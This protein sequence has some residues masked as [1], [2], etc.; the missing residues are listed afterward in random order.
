[1]SQW[2]PRLRR[3]SL[4][5]LGMVM[6]QHGYAAG[7]PVF[8][9]LAYLESLKQTIEQI[10]QSKTQLDQYQSMLK[11]S[12][13]LDHYT[14][15]QASLTMDN[16]LNAINTL[17][18][19]KQQSGGIDPYLA[20]YQTV[21]HYTTSSCLNGSGCSSAQ[22]QALNQ[23]QANASTAQKRAN[24]ASL[25]GVDKQQASIKADARQL[26]TLQ[27]QAQDADGQLQAIQAANQLASAETN[28]LLEIRGLLVAQQT[29]EAT[30]AAAE[31]DRQAIQTAA[32]ARFR[33]GSYKKSPPKSW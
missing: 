8:D 16:L 30:R 20:R 12:Q 28:Q 29:A 7:M 3:I 25:R 33:G 14:W 13:K 23:Q 24:D 21:D 2:L 18:S 11:N 27:K 19:Y 26:Q 32:D 4:S 15:D 1:M 10:A 9:G 6:C 5:L 31:L 22:L 17:E